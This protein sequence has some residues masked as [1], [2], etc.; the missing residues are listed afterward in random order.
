MK[1][2]AVNGS[3]RKS[4]NTGA[5]LEKVVEGAISKG[6]EAELVHLRDFQYRGC[7]S[8]F[9]CKDPQGSSYGR[10]ILKDDLRP[11]LDLAHEADVLVLGTP[12]YFSIETAMMRAF[13]ERLWFQYLLYTTKKPPLAPRKK[14]L[15]LVYTMNIKEEGMPAYGKDVVSGRAKGVMER[16]FAAPCELFLCTDTKQVPDYAKYEM[17]M[18]DASAKEKRHQEVFP[19][20]L[21]RAFD[22]GARLVS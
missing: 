11:I 22:M 16:L 1:L 15:A 8:C 9:H 13:M 19:K 10:C 12:F 2:L 5:L 7:M 6:A 3:P 21:A 17:D 14:A 20:D 18:W 4:M